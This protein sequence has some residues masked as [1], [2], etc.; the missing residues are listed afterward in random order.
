MPF[1]WRD[2][3]MHGAL[4]VTAMGTLL[5][6]APALAQVIAPI[7]RNLPPVISG[8]GRLMIGPQYLSGG[9]GIRIGAIGDISRPALEQAL[10]PF[11]GR[12][13][14]RKLISDIQAAIAKVYREAGYPF[15]SV[16]LPP[17]EVTSGVLTLRV[18]EFRTGAVKVSGAEAGTD[19]DLAGRV[20]AA[21]GQRISA[22]ALDEDLAWLNRYPYRSVNGVF[23]PG[24]DLG[25][26]TLTLEVTPQKPWQAFAGWSNTGTHSTGF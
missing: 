22:D 10:S 19:A 17:Q 25:L 14:S 6:A 18:V 8:Q 4:S 12:P 2:L 15:V 11:I 20:R 13:L 5:L 7:E 9:R 23:A 16:T 26:S 24:D 21:P 3:T 1:S